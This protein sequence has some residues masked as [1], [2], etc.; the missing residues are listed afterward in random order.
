ME[1][2]INFKAVSDLS[3]SVKANDEEYQALKEQLRAAGLRTC[4][5][6]AAMLSIMDNVAC[7]AYRE[8]VIKEGGKWDNVAQQ[9][10][11]KGAAVLANLE[12]LAR[13]GGDYYYNYDN[14]AFV[15]LDTNQRASSFADALKKEYI[16]FKRTGQQARTRKILSER[17][18]A[19]C[20]ELSSLLSGEQLVDA[21]A[22]ILHCSASQVSEAIRE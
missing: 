8:I 9:W 4:Y 2:K 6:N 15:C 21:V 16:R 12:K 14:K 11:E 17:I 1:F 20:A 19:Q 3:N 18:K 22:G 5:G 13:N 7:Q 10:D